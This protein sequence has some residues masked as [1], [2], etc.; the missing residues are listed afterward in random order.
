[1]SYALTALAEKTVE[2]IPSFDVEDA[3]KYS[4]NLEQRLGIIGQRLNW[5]DSQAG[6][7]FSVT[8]PAPTADLSAFRRV[9]NDLTNELVAMHVVHR[10]LESHHPMLAMNDVLAFIDELIVK[11]QYLTVKLL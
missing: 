2:G 8:A 11:A 1:M 3:R 5:V 4:K 7:A 6:S 10:A 9:L